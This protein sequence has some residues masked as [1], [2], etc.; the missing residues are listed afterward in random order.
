MLLP[1]AKNVKQMGPGFHIISF[2]IR[3]SLH[4]D[5]DFQWFG[6]YK[7]ACQGQ[8]T[9]IIICSCTPLA[10]FLEENNLGRTMV[11]LKTLNNCAS[12][13]GKYLNSGNGIQIQPIDIGHKEYIGLISADTAF[14]TLVKKSRLSQALTNS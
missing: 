3:K 7:M 13:R 1:V 11:K 8:A 9:T 2:W 10:C 6:K 4:D 12:S 14:W 5:F